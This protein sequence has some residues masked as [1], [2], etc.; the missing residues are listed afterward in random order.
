MNETHDNSGGLV[1]ATKSYVAETMH[2]PLDLQPWSGT[3]ALPRYLTNAY[4]ILQGTL[5]TT[6]ALWLFALDEPTPAAVEKHVSAITQ[7]WPDAQVVVFDRLPSYVRQ[8]LIE[9][10]ISFVVPGAQL[11]LPEHG[12]DFRSRSKQSARVGATLRPS[13][14][15]ML[16]YLLLHSGDSALAR[17]ASEL[18]PILGQSL[19]TASRAVAELEAH[20]LVRV[21]RVGRTKEV[22][23]S[24]GAREVWE[25]AQPLLRTPVIRRLTLVDGLP[26]SAGGHLLA[27]LRALSQ[28]SML[29]APRTPTYAVDRTTARASGMEDAAVARDW[30]SMADE[31]GAATVEIWSY[32]PAPLSDGVV[33]DPLS[34]SLSLRDD[35]DERVQGAVARLLEGLPW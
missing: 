30:P 22:R 20:G 29:A 18:A 16:L 7:W 27:G 26:E 6:R 32:D 9:R 14:Q 13:A 19:M 4:S 15:S 8:R 35:P 1:A 34:L 33:V 12:L 10:G 21:Q 31:A 17:S 2:A 11:Y 24:Q 23:L 28:Q 25:A 3:Q 5:G